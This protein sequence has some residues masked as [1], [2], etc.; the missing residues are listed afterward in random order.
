VNWFNNTRH[1]HYFLYLKCVGVVSGERGL[2]LPRKNVLQNYSVANRSLRNVNNVT[3]VNK[4]KL[5]SAYEYICIAEEFP[6]S[7][8]YR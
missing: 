8:V 6:I 4:F 2:P 7:N 3:I 5:F 1:S